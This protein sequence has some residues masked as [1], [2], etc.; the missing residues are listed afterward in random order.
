MIF[1]RVP[2]SPSNLPAAYHYAMLEIL[3]TL[4]IVR[5]RK[6]QPD[7]FPEGACETQEEKRMRRLTRTHSHRHFSRVSPV[8]KSE[9][10]ARLLD[11]FLL[12]MHKKVEGEYKCLEEPGGL[13]PSNLSS[14]VTFTLS[15]PLT[16]EK[17]EIGERE[18]IFHR[19]SEGKTNNLRFQGELKGKAKGK[20]LP[21]TE[22]KK[23]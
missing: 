20:S 16:H 13:R 18:T 2:G 15:S 11:A 3:E 6:T 21:R 22:F 17:A 10:L 12:R 8:S 7:S 19:F 4:E 5:R 1:L 9:R 14:Q 23:E